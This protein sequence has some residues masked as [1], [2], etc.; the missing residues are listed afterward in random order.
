MAGKNQLHLKLIEDYLVF[1]NK[2]RVGFFEQGSMLP[3]RYQ[4]AHASVEI[5]QQAGNYLN[6]WPE[7]YEQVKSLVKIIQPFNDTSIL[8]KYIEY[9]VGA[10]SSSIGLPFGWIC[11]SV[12]NAMGVAQAIVHELSHHKL[13]ALGIDENNTEVIFSNSQ[14]VTSPLNINQLVSPVIA[15][16]DMYT[17][18]HVLQL[19]ILMARLHFS[20]EER[21]R[22][23]QLLLKNMTRIAYALNCIVGNIEVASKYQRFYD[24]LIIWMDRSV[25]ESKHILSKSSLY[26]EYSIS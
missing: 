7:M 4:K 13:R 11:L 16:H 5:F 25:K 23:Y 14:Y 26:S 22:L 10:S 3:P 18:T 6:A 19:N 2:V 8:P 21:D 9:A 15:F 12:D 1:T 20:P 24:E 17:F